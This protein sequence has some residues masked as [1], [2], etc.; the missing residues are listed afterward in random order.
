MWMEERCK[1]SRLEAWK[2]WC[3]ISHAVSFPSMLIKKIPLLGTIP[4]GK[5]TRHSQGTQPPTQRTSTLELSGTSADF[6]W[7]RNKSFSSHCN[8]ATFVSVDSLEFFLIY[9]FLSLFIYFER[10][11]ESG[12]EAETEG[13]RESQA[14]SASSAQSRRRAQTHELS[15][16]RRLNPLNHPGAPLSISLKLAYYLSNF[17]SKNK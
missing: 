5:A 17:I 14:G 7:T 1:M 12:V 9:I 10:E 15:R 6:I 8:L 13:D 2:S 16:G 11:S 4:D 3:A